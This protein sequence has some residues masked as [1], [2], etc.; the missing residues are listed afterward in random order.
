MISPDNKYLVFLGKDGYIV[1]V[2]N[3]T[4]QWI[5]NMKMNGHVTTATFSR[6]GRFL[7]TG[8]G[9]QLN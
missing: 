3:K 8:G 6:D 5:G 7:Y 9:T 2:S 1:I 4:K